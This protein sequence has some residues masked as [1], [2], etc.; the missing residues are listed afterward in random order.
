[1][2]FSSFKKKYNLPWIDFPNN[3]FSEH[4][5]ATYYINEKEAIQY[6]SYQKKFLHYELEK[7]RWK[8]KI[9][10]EKEFKKHVKKNV[11]LLNFK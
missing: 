2:K 6:V 9:I 4:F 10:T 11:S 1:M 3:L 7:N 5:V 8:D